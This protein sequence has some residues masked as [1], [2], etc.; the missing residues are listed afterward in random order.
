M[1]ADDDPLYR[2]YTLRLLQS[3][4]DIT[5]VAVCNDALT[6]R[7]KIIACKP[8]F[9]IL[10]IEMPNLTGVQ[11][12]KSL[13]AMPLMIFITSHSS[14]AVDAYEIDAVDYLVKPVAAERLLRAV[15][16][17]KLLHQL[18]NQQSNDT[19]ISFKEA[20]SFFV[21]E[22]N[23]HVRVYYKDVLYF[24]SLGDFVNIHLKG[25]DKKIILVNMK[26]LEQ[27]LAEKTFLRIS[28]SYMVNTDAITSLTNDLIIINNTIQ[29][30]IGNTYTDAVQKYLAKSVVIKRNY[31]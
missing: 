10:D 29:L 25:G 6:A 3:I 24:E 17:V 26:N 23:S 28:R 22:K 7:E 27:Q 19:G 11:M 31:N 12:A 20:D 14:Y 8:D 13:K 2:D 5:C 9:V 18:K 21:K 16:K 1:L 4:T 30:T 15:D